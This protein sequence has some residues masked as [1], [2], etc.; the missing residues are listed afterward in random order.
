VAS[1]IVAAITLSCFHVTNLD[2][3]GH[4]TVGREI[5]L[6]K[7]IPSTDFFSHTAV[8]NPYPVHQW[9]GEVVLFGIEHLT[10]PTGLIVLRMLVVLISA[11][12]LYHNARRENAPAVVACAIVLLL[13]VA[14]RPRFFVRPFLVTLLFLPLLQAWIADLRQGRTRRLW[15]VLVLMG[16]WG[17]VHSGVIFGVLYLGGIV[18]G[19]GLKIV[20]TQGGK[21]DPERWPGEVLDGWNYRRLVIF[22]A[23]AIVLPFVTMAIVSPA[24]VKPLLLPFLFFQ[25]EGFR[26]MI[27]EYRPVDLAKDWP[28]EVV[29]GAILVGMAL[30][31]RRVD[32]TH[33]IIV[34]GF[35]FLAFQAVRGILPF[36]AVSAP[37]LGRTWGSVVEDLLER[38][39]GGRGKPSARVTRA[40]AAEAMAILL[41]V[42]AAVLFSVRSAQGWMFPFGFGLDPKH[43]PERALDFMYAQGVR[44]PIFNTDVWASS[45]LR[46]WH[47]RRFPVFVDARLEVYPEEFWRDTYYRVLQAG[48]GWRDVLRKY[49]VQ[50]AILRRE[51]GKID[52]RIG[53]ALWN[54]PDWALVYWDD[55][56]MVFARYGPDAPRRHDMII[57]NWETTTFLPRRPSEVTE[58]SGAMLA[59]AANEISQMAEWDP[60]SFLPHWALASAW[61]ELGEGEAAVEVFD[62][63]AS[64]KAARN[65]SAFAA[66]RAAAEIVAGDRERWVELIR[67]AGR[68]PDSA[69][70]L[71]KA[72][73]LL[74]KA[75]K[76]DAAIELYRGVLAVS[77]QDADAMN[78]LAVLLARDGESVAEALSLLEDAM[79]L[80]PQD[81]YY[82]ASRGE[83]Y[84]LAGDPARAR[85]DFERALELLPEEEVA[86]RNEVFRWLS[87]LE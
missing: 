78:N 50:S 30:R 38:A 8:G 62:R 33:L 64:R 43:Y 55:Y 7:S 53:E 21:S 83:V 51:P 49:N 5:V 20:L 9:F 1:V 23:I 25:N 60:D 41:V 77:P 24:G 26:A 67:E 54:E 32:L 36:V 70:E 61:T 57:P 2:I 47:G 75:G 31:P 82:V 52:D 66:S 28:F 84:W 3:G 29:A 59:E 18:F 58:L 4:V 65:N 56:V 86:A 74:K 13:L 71:F 63:L 27:A 68:D 73:L 76:L 11:M 42:G 72:A 37:M 34:A 46:R 40:N 19:E 39:T 48:P 14:A 81:G 87:R 10:G 15:P 85:A 69:S 80:R 22:S 79:R 12:L 6:T 16:M 17:H 35:G 44:G 45:L